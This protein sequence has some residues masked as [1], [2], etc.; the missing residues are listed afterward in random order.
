MDRRALK[1]AGRRLALRSTAL[2]G[3]GLMLALP[4]AHAAF[5]AI[6][7]NTAEQLGACRLELQRPR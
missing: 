3:V 5:A 1:R 4:T 2:L 7:R 6:T